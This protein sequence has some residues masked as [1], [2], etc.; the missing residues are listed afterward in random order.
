MSTPHILEDKRLL[1]SYDPTCNPV[2][3]YPRHVNVLAV[4]DPVHLRAYCK[5]KFEQFLDRVLNAPIPPAETGYRHTSHV[6]DIES[7]V[8]DTSKNTFFP[9]RR[10]K[11]KLAIP[12]DHDYNTP[13]LC[14]IRPRVIH[15]VK[16]ANCPT[17]KASTSKPTISMSNRNFL[18]T[19]DDPFVVSR[20]FII[21]H[22]ITYGMEYPSARSYLLDMF[23]HKS[24]RLAYRSGKVTIKPARAVTNR[25]EC[26]DKKIG[27]K[28]FPD[29]AQPSVNE[30]DS[31]VKPILCYK[32]FFP[33]KDTHR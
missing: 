24:Y 10:G 1:Y 17:S 9:L 25:A 6:L 23:G 26:V 16:Q 22:N 5:P 28:L 13:I 32:S 4:L 2:A 15:P 30:F 8:G 18:K 33:M 7:L 29:L 3:L 21:D 27:R 31:S 11:R 19:I 14:W 12:G 20:D